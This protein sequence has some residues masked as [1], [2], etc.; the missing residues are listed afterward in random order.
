MEDD[1]IWHYTRMNEQTYAEALAAV[2]GS[3]R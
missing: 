2:Q 3:G 1:N